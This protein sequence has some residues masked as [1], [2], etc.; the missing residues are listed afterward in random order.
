MFLVVH[1]ASFS[2]IFATFLTKKPGAFIHIGTGGNFI[3]NN[4]PA[5]ELGR[6]THTNE[7]GEETSDQLD[8]SKKTTNMRLSEDRGGGFNY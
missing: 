2:R 7:P 8:Q 1:Q 5:G 3:S 4:K 6:K